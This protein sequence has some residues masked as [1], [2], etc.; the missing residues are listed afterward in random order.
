[1]SDHLNIGIL[2]TRL[3]DWGGGVDLLRI[4]LGAFH[5]KS[6]DRKIRLT[7]FLPCIKT[8]V[9]RQ[10]HFHRGLAALL[11]RRP[12]QGLREVYWQIRKVNPHR[13]GRDKILSVLAQ[14]GAKFDIRCYTHE[15]ELIR[16][17]ERHAIKVIIPS[18]K[19]LGK[20][21]PVPW[22]GYLPD[23]QH[24][25]LPEL[26]SPDECISR[27]EQFLSVLQSATAMVVTSQA[28][29]RD[30]ETFYPGMASQ[31]FVWPF[32][33]YPFK[34]WFDES[35]TNVMNKYDLPARY[36]LISSQF[37][38]H[39]SHITAIEALALLRDHPGYSDVKLVCTGAT[40][41]YRHPGYF[42][43]LQCRIADLGLTDAIMILGHIPKRDQIEIM[44]KSVGLIQPTLFE[45][46][47]GGLAVYDAVGLGIRAIVSDIPVNLEIQN[48]LVTFFHAGS[49]QDLACKLLCILCEEPPKVDKI[50]Q[51]QLA[52][53]RIALLGNVL[54]DGVDT[55]IKDFR[56]KIHAV[57]IPKQ[58]DNI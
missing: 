51:L 7:L 57:A 38:R 34:E 49:I 21:F 33:P 44:K 46:T 50:Y 6:I 55:A 9:S 1:M 25:R 29:K 11:S 24:K 26:F 52:R 13:I 27:D 31:I 47:Q 39:K 18:Y 35:D 32:T 20:N 40:D 14:S 19:N 42:A 17:I 30:I 43:E 4:V 41:D 58:P 8:E 45:G 10:T 2:G 36:F 3:I 12:V 54:I 16:L 37:W 23:L 22:I 56:Y 53:S 5:E 15:A 28:V 48:P